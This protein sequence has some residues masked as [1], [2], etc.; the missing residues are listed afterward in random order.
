VDVVFLVGFLLRRNVYLVPSSGLL[1][2]MNVH[3]VL[4]LGEDVGRD[5][6]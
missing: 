1:N 6:Y 5:V 4:L 2:R 3:L